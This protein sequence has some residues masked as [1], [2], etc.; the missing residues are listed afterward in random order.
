MNNCIRL[1]EFIDGGRRDVSYNEDLKAEFKKL[2]RAALKEI[3]NSLQSNGV[4]SSFVV[5]FNPGGIAVSGDHHLRALYPSGG[6]FDLF[7]SLGLDFLVYRRT[8]GMTDYTGERNNNLPLSTFVTPDV[9][10]S[11]L[12]RLGAS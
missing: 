11:A 12:T 2:G 8:T 5:D 3:G 9:I 7:F 6:G 10:V 4:I 1:A